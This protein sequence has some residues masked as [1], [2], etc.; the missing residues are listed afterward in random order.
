MSKVLNTIKLIISRLKSFFTIAE[1]K[2]LAFIQRHSGPN[3][4][5]LW[6]LLQTPATMSVTSLWG[7]KIIFNA[8]MLFTLAFMLLFT[9]GGVTGVI[10]SNASLNVS[11]YDTY[12]VIAHF[13]YVLSIGAT[14]AVFWLYRISKLNKI[15]YFIKS[16]A[17]QYSRY[18]LVIPSV[19]IMLED[20]LKEFIDLVGGW[21]PIQIA[22]ATILLLL[23]W[24]LRAGYIRNNIKG[25]EEDWRVLT[26]AIIA[27]TIIAPWALLFI[28]ACL[29]NKRFRN[30][31]Y[32]N[33]FWQ[34]LLAW[35]IFVVLTSKVGPKGLLVPKHLTFEQWIVVWI[36]I[37]LVAFII[38]WLSLYIRDY[39]IWREWKTRTGSN[40][41]KKK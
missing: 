35:F 2:L 29:F 1:R 26:I 38:P 16:E 28:K 6:E 32:D 10:L 19:S 21:L 4:T 9:L 36:I 30:I 14:F 25:N 13:H 7:G 22:A 23:L 20:F 11:L 24:G 39:F 15:H 27:L 5:G 33:W 34:I 8:P 17:I 12:Y 31:I 3:V 40:F 41:G 18:N 37:I